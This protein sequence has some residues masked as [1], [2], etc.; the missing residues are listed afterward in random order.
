MSMPL[1]SQQ[2]EDPQDAR[3]PQDKK[4]EV[5]RLQSE[6]ANEVA[7]DAPEIAQGI[8]GDNASHPDMAQV[9]NQQLDQVYRQKFLSGSPDDRQ[10]LQTEARRDPAQFLDV[11]K[12]IGV[13]MP[14]P[15]PPAPPPPPPMPAPMPMIPPMA[16]SPVPTPMVPP[17][18]P[19]PV[20]QPLA[21]G[22]MTPGPA[23][24][25]GPAPV[26]LGP[27]GQPLPPSGLM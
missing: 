21:P 25:A 16:T 11:A 5:V 8:F 12:R 13:A 18:S 15:Q 14:P 27:N 23:P 19:A 6:I 22:P 24:Q 9:S 7:R 4:N 2:P 10:W 26:I 3:P 20:P 1:P 17:P